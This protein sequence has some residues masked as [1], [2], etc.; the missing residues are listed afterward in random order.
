MA[1]VGGE[2]L[3]SWF[4]VNIWLRLAAIDID[5]R[6][7]VGVDVRRRIALLYDALEGKECANW[8]DGIVE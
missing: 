5:S 4:C 7:E 8:N 3:I 6:I 1:V 2:Y